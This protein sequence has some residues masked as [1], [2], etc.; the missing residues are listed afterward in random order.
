[1]TVDALAPPFATYREA[2]LILA[3]TALLLAMWWLA[4]CFRKKSRR[5]E[6]RGP[7]LGAI[8]LTALTVLA[9]FRWRLRPNW[10]GAP[11]AVAQ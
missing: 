7:L 8:L 4:E 5:W 1:M 10:A 3:G 9:Y 2:T 11:P 6:R